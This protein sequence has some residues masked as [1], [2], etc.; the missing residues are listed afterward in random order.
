MFLTPPDTRFL[1]VRIL[2]NVLWDALFDT[3]PFKPLESALNVLVVSKLDNYHNY[4]A[5]SGRI[6]GSL[7]RIRGT[8]DRTRRST[9]LGCWPKS[10]RIYFKAQTNMYISS[11]GDCQHHPGSNPNPHLVRAIQPDHT[12]YFRAQIRTE[13]LGAGRPRWPSSEA[14]PDPQPRALCCAPDAASSTG[15][16]ASAVVGTS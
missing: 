9:G 16:P 7:A 10:L 8:R 14:W 1:V 12:H 6:V 11:L 2:P 13:P 15:T 3:L 4:H 5:L